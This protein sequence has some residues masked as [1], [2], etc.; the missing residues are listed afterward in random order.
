M[1]LHNTIPLRLLTAATLLA[2]ACTTPQKGDLLFHVTA[3]RNAI[4]D[5]TPG[6]IDHV[7]IVVAP[8]SVIEAVGRG[9]VV[10]PL[11][12]L[13]CQQGYYLIGRV[14]NANRQLSV[15]NARKYLGRD[16]DWLYLP[17]NEAVYCSELVQLSFVDGNGQRL[18]A[19]IPMSFHDATG[20]ITSYW[21]EFYEKKGMEVPEGKLGTNPGEMS[22]RACVSIK[23]KLR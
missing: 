4:T 18:F 3:D 13:R 2:T 17:D 1:K 15:D 10:T 12:S 14:K 22:R 20:K 21:R 9:V 23:G 8:D 6:M 5:V 11:D 7:A 16:Y 19:P